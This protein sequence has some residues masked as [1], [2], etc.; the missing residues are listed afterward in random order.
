VTADVL[1]PEPLVLP[2]H[3]KLPAPDGA[4]GLE[5]VVLTRDNH[6]A[7]EEVEE[8]STGGALAPADDPVG[9]GLT[10]EPAT[11]ATGDVPAEPVD[12]ATQ[13]VTGTDGDKAQAAAPAATTNPSS[14]AAPADGG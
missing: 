5:P 3:V 14:G 9:E 6:A 4:A 1:G 10:S 13:A 11:D 12:G 7:G 8:E 2:G